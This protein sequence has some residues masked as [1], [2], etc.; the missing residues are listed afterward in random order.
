MMDEATFYDQLGLPRDASLEEIRHAY[1][2]LVLRLHPDRNVKPGET[3]I[4]IE[5]QQA[6]EHLADPI[7]KA[8][9]DKQL[10]A[11][12]RYSNPLIVKT[13]Y[14]Q[15]S[16]VPLDEAQLLYTLL[17]MNLHPD[18]GMLISSTPLNIS[19][20]VDCST[21][22][23]GIRLDTVKQTAIDLIRQL[24]PNDIFSL[25]KFNDRAELLIPAGFLV[26]EK[27]TEMKVQL[28]QAGGGTEIFKGIEMGFTQVNQYRSRSRVNHII[29]IT[30]GR[31]YGD[32]ASC[33][34]LANQSSALGIGISTL[35]I[36][37]QWNDK[38]L[39]QISSKTGGICKY[40]S[41]INDI[42][43]IILGEITRLGTS[44]TEQINFTYLPAPDVEISSAFRLQP[45]AS[46][47][48]TGSPMNFG[49]MPSTGTMNIILEFVVKNLQRD[50]K[51]FTLA[52]GFINYEIPRHPVKTRYV[53]RMIFNRPV[54]VTPGSE[55]PPTKILNAMSLLSVYQMQERAREEMGRGDVNSATRH[56]KFLATH[57]L[58]R[59]ENNLA[60]SILDEVAYI[61]KYQSFS[62]DG[63]KRIKYG[64]RSLLLPARIEE[65]KL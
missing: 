2:Q 43:N 53:Q 34:E 33:E 44:L 32:E 29:L 10:G 49:F 22:M 50:L 38:F 20:V 62:E 60:Q 36:G 11:E 19:L 25:V 12:Q 58:K 21:S 27:S 41:D 40:I 17:E 48:V 42:R 55:T 28:L 61:Q 37:N 46:P 3:E 6:Y 7:R 52:N 4:F 56:M 23:R 63:E 45:D 13:Y 65:S 47:L 51:A 39:D 16:M 1:R 64:T 57:L 30:D 35:G 26:E 59:G 31:T 54:S 18:T 9:Y 8:E 24:K 14:S 5:L 15:S